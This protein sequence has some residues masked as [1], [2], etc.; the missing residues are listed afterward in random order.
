MEAVPTDVWGVVPPLDC[1]DVSNS[2]WC[3]GYAIYWCLLI[4]RNA[5]KTFPDP[6][7]DVL[8]FFMTIGSPAL[9][10]YSLQITHLNTRWLRKAFLHLEYPNSK[11]ISTVI[12]TFQHIPLQISPNPLLLPSLIVLPQ[13][14]AYW[15]LLL[16]CT[17]RTRRWSI[18]LVMNFIWVIFP[19]LFTIIDS[20]HQERTAYAIVSIWTYL[21]PLIMGWLHVGCQPEPNHL[22]DCLDTANRI[23][24]VAT[25]QK[26]GPIQAIEIAGQL[27]QALKLAKDGADVTEEDELRT[28]PVF[29]YSRTFTWSLKAQHILSLV[30]NAAAKAERQIPVDNYGSG[31][32]AVWVAGDHGGVA[33]ENRLGTNE[34]V[35][36]YC[37]EGTTP[38][39]K[40]FRAPR[41]VVPPG[42]IFSRAPST[43]VAL[44]PF[45][46]SH[47]IRTPSRWA[48][49][50]WTRVVFATLLALELQWGGVGAAVMI[51][52]KKRP[53][54]LGC[55]ALMFLVYGLAATVAFF[56][57][58]TSSVLAH[59]SR[60]QHGQPYRRSWTQTCLNGGAVLCG[61]LGR[62]LAV[63]SGIGILVLSSA[64][65]SGAFHSC[66]CA[67]VTFNGGIRFHDVAYLPTIVD[68][69]PKVI[70]VLIGGLGL[71]FSTAVLFGISIYLCTPPR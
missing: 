32:D 28:S 21:L 48:S 7:D 1:A 25:D 44:L 17:E 45:Y 29:N 49:G 71:A 70:E 23:A 46:D 31:C 41:P 68:V 67:S 53:Y 8:N 36:D 33:K 3:G 16:K 35:I 13:N 56:L 47:N 10:A 12:S 42:H 50:V 62:I 9:A 37:T 64:N 38:F 59:I 63:A 52:Y 22:R 2:I 11:A 55:G 6:L 24:W 54:G 14:D 61:Y 15:D 43:P 69:G 39:E 65:Y 40:V 51:N 18:P 58:L 20:L 34:Q 66:Y 30:K 26:D 4:F 57:C 19:V 27:T 5:H 60:P